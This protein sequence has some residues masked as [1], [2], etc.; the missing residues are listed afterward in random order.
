MCM[1]SD[2]DRSN[3]HAHGSGWGGMPLY[4]IV[5]LPAVQL[6]RCIIYEF[7]FALVAHGTFPATPY[8]SHFL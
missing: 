7:I 8:P 3:A 2:G 4:I 1:R 5:S 6:K